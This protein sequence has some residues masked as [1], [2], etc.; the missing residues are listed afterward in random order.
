MIIRRHDIPIPNVASH[1]LSEDE[2]RERAKTLAKSER[3]QRA[4][5]EKQRLIVTKEAFNNE[6]LDHNSLVEISYYAGTLFELD[7][8]PVIERKLRKKVQ[9]LK[10]RGLTKSQI[11]DE[12]DLSIYKVEKYF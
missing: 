6:S 5:N 11:A 2:I 12:I 3:F 7:I 9:A 4:K 8:K 10:K 1:L